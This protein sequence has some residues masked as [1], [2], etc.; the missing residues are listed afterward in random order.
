MMTCVLAT[1]CFPQEIHSS[2]SPSRGLRHSWPSQSYPPSQRHPRSG[3]AFYHSEASTFLRSLPLQNP[4]L[5][6]VFSTLRSS[7]SRRSLLRTKS[8]NK[9]IVH[10]LRRYLSTL[11]SPTF[12]TCNVPI[13][14]SSYGQWDSSA[15]NPNRPTPIIMIITTNL[16]RAGRAIAIPQFRIHVS[17]HVRYI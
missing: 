12:M 17:I 14:A 10:D 13:S 5:L 6:W 1:R 15:C 9:Q 2:Q 3:T 16:T 4:H 8:S 7:S 11:S